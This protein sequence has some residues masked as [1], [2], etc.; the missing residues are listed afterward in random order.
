MSR[1]PFTERK[2]LLVGEQQRDTVL[3]LVRNLPLDADNPLEVVVRERVKGRKMSQQ[4]L[5]FAGPMTDIANQA[6]LDGRQFSVEIWHE[7][8]KREFLPEEFDPE[9]CKEGYE[10]YSLDPKGERIMI[11]STTQLTVKGYSNY[12]EQVF[13]FGANLGVLFSASPNER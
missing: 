8:M 4:A 5:L 11:G 2:V 10:K 9:Q 12:L 13:A 3:N 7:F 1:P 6:W